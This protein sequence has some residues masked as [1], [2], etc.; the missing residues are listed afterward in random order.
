MSTVVG[1]SSDR[2]PSLPT[3]L[4]RGLLAAFRWAT[5][6][7][8]RARWT[9]LPALSGVTM[10][11]MLVGATLAAPREII[12]G[13]VQRLMYLH[14]PSASVGTYMSFLITAIAS[15]AFLTT[16]DIRWDAV[17]RGAATVGVL[18][19]V[20]TLA[21]GA[22]W[23]KP[24]WGVY[25]TWDARL[26]STLVL[27]LI[28]TAYLLARS[29][30]G[31]NDEQAARYSAIFAVIGFIDIPIIHFSVDWWRT[32]HPQRIVFDS[33]PSMP[34]EMLFVLFLGFIA[35]TFLM[36]WLVAL[37]SEAEQLGQRTD[38]MRARLDHGTAG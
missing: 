9:L 16:R 36:L 30:G 3:T 5:L 12:E 25:W 15:V 11:A 17:A 8:Y 22:I 10:M 32:L 19:T 29:V 34:G 24:T 37:R 13:E 7:A 14:V 18:F 20:L 28:Y 38:R 2:G 35:I 1:S 23:G 26:T 27:L 33:R 21:T 4:L 6:P 31:P